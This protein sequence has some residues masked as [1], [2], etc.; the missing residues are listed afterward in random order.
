[1]IEE[2]IEW[3]RWASTN[4]DGLGYRSPWLDIMRGHVCVTRGATRAN[5]SDDKAL[6]IE[7]AVTRL[8]GHSPHLCNVLCLYYI[9]GWTLRRIAIEY[10]TPLEYPDDDTKRVSHHTASNLVNR[11]T[12]MIEGYLLNSV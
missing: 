4:D 10:L 6:R 11:A 3:G 12:G 2:L 8:Y 1:M 7:Q 5:I 9:G